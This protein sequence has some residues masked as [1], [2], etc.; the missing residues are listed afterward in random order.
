M[1]HQS[2]WDMG[3]WT[4]VSK[5]VGP[6]ITVMSR[7]NS[8]GAP[9]FPK[10]EVNRCSWSL[11]Q[12][13]YASCHVLLVFSERR[14]RFS[15]FWEV[16]L[17]YTR[18]EE[19]NW[20]RKMWVEPLNSQRGNERWWVVTIHPSTKNALPLQWPS[21]SCPRAFS[22]LSLPRGPGLRTFGGSRTPPSCPPQMENCHRGLP[23]PLSPSA[24]PLT[25]IHRRA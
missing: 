15:C 6:A 19:G 17:W 21:T 8:C 13:L 11:V 14:H 23:Q 3:E 9:V 18:Q 10:Y 12:L 4:T 24:G 20:K 7:R 2:W 16:F 22:Q 1:E 5:C 25:R